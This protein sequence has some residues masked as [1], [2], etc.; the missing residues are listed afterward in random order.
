ML[1]K[2]WRYKIFYVT[3]E[4][5]FRKKGNETRGM[6]KGMIPGGER[7][8]ILTT[9]KFIKMRNRDYIYKKLES[10][11]STLST[12]RHMVSTSQPIDAFIA[13]IEKGMDTIEEIKS[14]VENEPQSP[15]EMNRL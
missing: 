9:I 6:N 2:T 4:Y 1:R 10:L 12:L 15:G 7:I 13:E 11:D 5:G 8:I 3:S 14:Q